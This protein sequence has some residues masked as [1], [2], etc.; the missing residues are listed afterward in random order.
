VTAPTFRAADV[1]PILE[2]T[3]NMPPAPALE[4]L[5]SDPRIPPITEE[6]VR[7]KTSISVF[8]ALEPIEPPQA[9]TSRFVFVRPYVTAGEDYEPVRD[10]DWINCPETVIWRD[11]Y[12]FGGGLGF[13]ALKETPN[14]RGQ[15]EPSEE[16]PE[17]WAHPTRAFWIVA[18][19]VVT[20]IREF[21]VSEFETVPIAWTEDSDKA[22]QGYVMFDALLLVDS[23]DYPR[24]LV[25]ANLNNAELFLHLSYKRTFREDVADSIHMFRDVY[26]R[27]T[28]VISRAL[29]RHLREHKVRGLYAVD[30]ANNRDALYHEGRARD[31]DVLSQF[32]Y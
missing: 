32:E 7:R 31:E 12:T 19:R 23:Y 10:M 28:V 30:P 27:K 18:P 25:T 29:W 11:P 1:T 15:L 22:F 26:D 14:I 5:K 6:H 16:A 4:S 13:S 20:L 24:C 17:I 8:A 21:G 9:A 2:G 3:W